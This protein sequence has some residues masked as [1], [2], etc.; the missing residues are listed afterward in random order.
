MSHDNAM[1]ITFE[2]A[3]GAPGLGVRPGLCHRGIREFCRRHHLD[4]PAIVAAGGIDEDA[5]RATGDALALALIE[6]ARKQEAGHGR[7]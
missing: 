5:L 3:H 7:K 6:H 1:K 4:W 2:H